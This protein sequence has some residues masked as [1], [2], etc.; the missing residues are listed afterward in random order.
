MCNTYTVRPKLGAIAHERAVNEAIAKLKVSL[1]RRSAPGV[2]VL[3]TE[4]VL[5]PE[6]MRWGFH[7]P[8]SDSI[9]NTRSAKFTS[10]MWRESL[11]LRRCLVPITTFFEWKPETG[12]R[13]QAYEFRR[14]DGEWMWVAGIYERTEAHGGCFATL[15]TEP[16]SVVEPIHDR[17]LAILEFNE[18]LA[19]LHGDTLPLAPY[20]GEIL[21]VPCDSPL[22]KPR[23]DKG[24]PQGELF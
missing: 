10:P 17:M 23:P 5:H 16:S 19:F 7:R 18:A 4:G 24:E 22:K 3:A 2:V 1:V 6:I 12:G 8:F 14:P 15:T 11:A 21:A 13:K 9:N 20:T